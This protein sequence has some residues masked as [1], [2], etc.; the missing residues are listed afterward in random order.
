MRGNV[1]DLAVGVIIGAAFGKVVSSVVDDILMPPIGILIGGVDFKDLK[2]MLRDPVMDAAGAVVTEGVS[3]NYG[4]FIQTLIDFAIIA[5]SIFVVVK[6]MNTLKR[7]K[8]ESPSVPPA[9]TKEEVLLTE[10][11]DAIRGGRPM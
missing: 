5:F 3:I 1:V 9:P 2:L 7:K 10:I 8:A 4:N 6:V 11:R